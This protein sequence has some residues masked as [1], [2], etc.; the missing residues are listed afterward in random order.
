MMYD[1]GKIVRFR[2]L[3]N[4]KTG[5]T[6]I[7]PM[8]HGAVL[9]PVSG[10]ED[11]KDTIDKVVKGGAD[12]LLLNAG[13]MKYCATEHLGKVGIILRLSSNN[14]LSPE[15]P[16]ET[17]VASVEKAV[18]LGADAVAF[19]VNVGGEKDVEAL[20]LFGAVADACTQY[21][22]PL[23]GEFLPAGKKVDNPYDAK[24]VKIVA[25]M[26][27]E[28]GADIIKTNYTGSPESF[29]EVVKSCPVPIVI[30]GGPKTETLKDA[31]EMVKGAMEAGAI[32]VCIGRNTW[33]AKNP[34]AMARAISK[35]VHEGISVDEALK[36]LELE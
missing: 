6:Y 27:A 14:I 15:S 24:W 23:L 10:I 22:I 2:R 29:K 8:D 3:L 9:G 34:T 18:K 31:L 36:E 25:R 20:R 12:S 13:V 16:F 35:I 4:P 7:V 17:A 5:K 32:G 28:L 26:G 11:I 19:T 33:Q 30:A 21:S 1:I